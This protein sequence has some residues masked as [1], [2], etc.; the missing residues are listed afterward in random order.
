MKRRGLFGFLAMAPIAVATG[1]NAAAQNQKKPEPDCDKPLFKDC[2]IWM[3]SGI[4][5]QH[6]TPVEQYR[7][8]H[9]LH[10]APAQTDM[11]NHGSMIMHEGELFIR[12]EHGD[13]RKIS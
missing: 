3:Q 6:G 2:S 9:A 10:F 1:A 7:P 12:S 11:K 4:T 13:W 5:F 8:P